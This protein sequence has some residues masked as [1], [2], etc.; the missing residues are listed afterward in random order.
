M[1]PVVVSQVRFPAVQC[2]I[3]APPFPNYS[4]DQK[5]RRRQGTH[6]FKWD[7]CCQIHRFFFLQR[8]SNNLGLVERCRYQVDWGLPKLRRQDKSSQSIR[9]W[10]ETGRNRFRQCKPSP[11]FTLS[12]RSKPLDFLS[13]YFDMPSRPGWWCS[14]TGTARSGD[15]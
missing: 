9:K 2:A 14:I 5:R 13:A 10:Y 8:L 4:Y 11:R 6:G 12:R 3:Y 7:V 1:A 15:S